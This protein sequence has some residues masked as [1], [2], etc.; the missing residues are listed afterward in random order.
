MIAR[1]IIHVLNNG[2]YCLRRC[3]QRD[4]GDIQSSDILK[5]VR[6]NYFKCLF[7][8]KRYVFICSKLSIS[9]PRPRETS[10]GLHDLAQNQG[11]ITDL[12]N[13]GCYKMFYRMFLHHL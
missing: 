4:P 12:F 8:L 3:K 7:I 11:S 10:V 6:F 5:L 13:V 9:Q 1:H 2:L